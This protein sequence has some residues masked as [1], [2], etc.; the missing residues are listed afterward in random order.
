MNSI[1]WYNYRVWCL[2][3]MKLRHLSSLVSLYIISLV[4]IS[5]L[6]IFIHFWYDFSKA[7]LRLRYFR[8]NLILHVELIMCFFDIVFFLLIGI[9]WLQLLGWVSWLLF[10]GA[11]ER[12]RVFLR[13]LF[14]FFKK[15]GVQI[16]TSLVMDFKDIFHR[17][18]LTVLICWLRST[19]TE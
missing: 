11:A 1:N 10:S 17:R 19:V 12:V 5:N 3:T 14:G 16:V 2:L 7:S 8:I 18:G 6:I 9:F 13:L 4:Y 15:H